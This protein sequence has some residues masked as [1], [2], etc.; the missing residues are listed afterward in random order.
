MEEARA[1][2]ERLEARVAGRRSHTRAACIERCHRA[3]PCLR[4]QAARHARR[5]LAAATCAPIRLWAGTPLRLQTSQPP[6]TVAGHPPSSRSRRKWAVLPP[7]APTLRASARAVAAQQRAIAHLRKQKPTVFDRCHPRRHSRKY[8]PALPRTR[9]RDQR[10]LRQ[11]CQ[12]GSHQH[13]VAAAA[14]LHANVAAVEAVVMTTPDFATPEARRG[15]A[16]YLAEV[17]AEVAAVVAAEVEARAA[18]IAAMPQ[19]VAHCTRCTR[20]TCSSRTQTQRP[21]RRSANTPGGTC[22]RLAWANM[23]PS[24]IQHEAMRRAC[25]QENLW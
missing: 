22:R 25:M 19:V 11:S 23:P 20:H 14:A 13:D 4:P 1:A 16:P 8:R 21:H 18:E 15:G 17:K 12:L 5:S 3:W 6:E 2:T 24:Q 10:A 9:P 7:K